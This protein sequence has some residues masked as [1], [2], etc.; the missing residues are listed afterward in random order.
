MLFDV[1]DNLA[2]EMI[3][4][5]SIV[6]VS[7]MQV[8]PTGFIDFAKPFVLPT[9]STFKD[10]GGRANVVAVVYLPDPV[11]QLMPAQVSS[12][13]MCLGCIY[14]LKL[15]LRPDITPGTNTNSE[16]GNASTTPNPQLMDGTS[17]QKA[18][19]DDYDF[20]STYPMGPNL[21]AFDP[22]LTHPVVGEGGRGLRR[23]ARRHVIASTFSLS[24]HHDTASST[25]QTQAGNV[26]ASEARIVDPQDVRSVAL[27]QVMAQ[28]NGSS[29]DSGST[30]VLY[31]T[32][33]VSNG[34][35]SPATHSVESSP[36]NAHRSP[37]ADGSDRA[38][39]ALQEAEDAFMAADLKYD[40]AREAQN[41]E[42]L[43]VNE[44]VEVSSTIAPH[45]WYLRSVA[46]CNCSANSSVFIM[47]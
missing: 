4:M 8:G 25:T 22:P 13:A 40:A 47:M 44:P 33:P 31:A 10:I 24:A 16:F 15:P 17:S 37:H 36:F 3:D 26:G 38:Q 14:S 43:D 2:L 41:R 21:T 9:G 23:T 46:S 7:S 20:M 19:D 1:L 12:Y 34:M 11:Q 5:L 29:E 27:A 28:S 30:Q 32:S 35:R 18:S 42:D 45:S 6:C 39:E